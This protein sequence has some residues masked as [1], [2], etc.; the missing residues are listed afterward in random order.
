MTWT[1]R[2]L[3]GLLIAALALFYGVL[4]P[5]V[6]AGMNRVEPHEPY[7]VSAHA[8]ALHAATPVA[9]LHADTLLWMR[10]PARRHARGHT[11]I[12][13]LREGGMFL[14]VFTA[15]TK[16]PAGQN[17]EEN[18]AGSDRITLLAL[19]QRWPRRT[20][21]SIEER[22][23][24][25]AQRLHEAAADDK[26][27]AVILSREDLEAA[28]EARSARPDMMAGILGTEGSHPLEGDLAAIGRLF[29]DGYRVMGLQHFFDNALGGS[30][31]GE[32]KSG[33]TAF[34]REAVAEMDRLGIVV[35][36]A[37]SAEAVVEDVLAMTDRPVI[38]SHTGFQGHCPSPR[39]ISDELMGRIAEAGGLIGV[40]FWADV[41]CDAS[42]EG[43]ADAIAYGIDRFG[44][45]AIALGSDFDGTVTTRLDATELP[46]LTEALLRRGLNERQVR[47]VMGGNAVRFFLDTLPGKAEQT[48]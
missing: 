42:P 16:T 14:Q 29:A 43:I 25:Q 5:R 30:L 4:P 18:D 15:V 11:D 1:I 19:A 17:Y 13:R 34:G 40:G 36:V 32:A 47:K 44:E 2:I 9:D 23:R 35:D 26:G 21:G 37:H 45:D 33:L 20:W 39:N 8:E 48:L 22:A 41:V 31:H 10:D 38:V 27:F 24:Y 28:L 3:A 7:S 6:D 12:P 46:A